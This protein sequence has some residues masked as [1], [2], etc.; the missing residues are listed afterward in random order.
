MGRDLSYNL[1]IVFLLAFL[2]VNLL[3]GIYSGR[4]IRTIKEYAIGNRN[5][6]TSTLVATIVATWISAN[7]ITIKISEAYNSGLYHIIPGIGDAASLFIVALFIA[8]K[9]EEFLGCL[10]VAEAMGK[11]YGSKARA[12]TSILGIFPAVGIVAAEFI[13][14]SVL[15]QSI[16]GIASLYA[17]LLSAFIVICYSTF[18]GIKSVTFTDMIQFFTFCLVIPTIGVA[19]IENIAHTN[20]IFEYMKHSELYEVKEVFNTSNPKF[21][22]CLVLFAFFLIPGIDPAIFQRISM[23]KD[24][25]QVKKAFLIAASLCCLIGFMFYFIAIAIAAQETLN[26]SNNDLILHIIDNYTPT[27]LKGIAI[28]GILAML[29]STADSY[30]NSSSILFSHDLCESIGL[31]LSKASELLL[32]RFSA[33]FIG[34]AA[35]ILSL[36]SSNMLEIIM[37]TCSFYMP[38]VTVT[39]LLAIFGFR[40][41]TKVALSGMFGGFITIVYFMLFSDVDG[42]IH[43]IFANMLVTFGGHYL[44]DQ[45]GGW[46]T[47]QDELVNKNT[48]TKKEFFEKLKQFFDN[49]N[50]MDFCRCNTPSEEKYFVYLGLINIVL[51]ISYAFALHR[52]T[53]IMYHSLVKFLEYSIFVLATILITYPIW[54]QKFKKLDFMPILWNFTIF[55][56]LAFSSSLFL[57]LSKFD[58]TM[59]TIMIVCLMTLSLLVRWQ[60]AIFMM[61]VGIFISFKFFQFNYGISDITADFSSDFKVIFSLLVICI[62]LVAFLKPKQEYQE[63]TE[64]KLDYQNTK[65]DNQKKELVQTLE[66]KN[67]FLRNL[68]HEARTPVMTIT[69][70]SQ[71]LYDNYDRLNDEQ[72][73]QIAK[74]ISNNFTRLSSFVNN[75]TDISK[76]SGRNSDLKKERVNL[77]K[78]LYE[79]VKFC[80][81]IYI[82]DDMKNSRNF[83]TEIEDGIEYKCDKHYISNTIDNIIINAIQYCKTG[84]IEVSLYKSKD[85]VEFSVADEGLGIPQNELYDIFGVFSVSSR[86]KSIAGGRGIG[87][88]LCKEAIEAHGGK[89]WAESDN[90]GSVFKFLLPW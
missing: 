38:V 88:A 62:I 48:K 57:I 36:Y 11:L 18:G 70:M 6:A 90:K 79:R 78:L 60:V 56:V 73:K 71:A 25:K 82:S 20:S 76:L 51:V 55:F 3:A 33:F 27:Y 30:I 9:M 4:G 65:M 44:F 74:E 81:K 29:M 42:F 2:L 49:F 23:A 39:L 64:T 59:L 28:V 24:T 45:E 86:T 8:P 43:A 83:I 67:E 54:Q 34:V 35:L 53:Q 40:T 66:I 16:T 87:L 75:L 89:I 12:V 19:V 17:S 47:K 14:S 26:L 1:D 61:F 31:K 37:T 68:N 46:K 22:S 52:D 77:S 7:F 5:F 41:S 69:S 50:I 84:K 85:G 63:I 15:L 13:I 32:A 10:S 58:Q 80:K 21:F 72:R